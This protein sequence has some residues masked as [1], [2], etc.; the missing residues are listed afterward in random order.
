MKRNVPLGKER[1][2]RNGR[3]TSTLFRHHDK[4]LCTQKQPERHLV[5]FVYLFIR[6]SLKHVGLDLIA[7][8]VS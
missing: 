5:I 2:E 4:S 6:F 1:K 3:D 8:L 7:L